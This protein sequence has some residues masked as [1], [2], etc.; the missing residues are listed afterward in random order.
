MR[1]ATIEALSATSDPVPPLLFVEILTLHR[2]LD[3]HLLNA[4]E[5]LTPAPGGNPAA[6][7]EPRTEEA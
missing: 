4:L 3:S 6:S 5:A 7:E 2:R 1:R